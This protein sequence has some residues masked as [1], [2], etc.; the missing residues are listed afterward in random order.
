MTQLKMKSSIEKQ[1]DLLERR[2]KRPLKKRVF[3]LGDVRGTVLTWNLNGCC[4]NAL[5]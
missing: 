1:F 4:V 2:Q 5:G 3:Q